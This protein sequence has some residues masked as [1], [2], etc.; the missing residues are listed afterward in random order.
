MFTSRNNEAGLAASGYTYLKYNDGVYV[1]V[2]ST[3]SGDIKAEVTIKNSKIKDIK[4]IE[5]PSEYITSNPAIKDDIS[6]FIY[7]TIKS[8]NISATGRS[9]NGSY[10]LN[11]AVKAVRNA[12]DQSLLEQ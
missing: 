4:M 2:E 3:E 11:K 5:L 1:G 9:S 7:D 10:V 8:Q 12:L 6:S